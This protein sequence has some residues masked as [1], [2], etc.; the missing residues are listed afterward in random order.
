M[1]SQHMAFV[2]AVPLLCM[3]H[4]SHRELLTPVFCVY[5]HIT[6]LS[7][8]SLYKKGTPPLLPC[9]VFP[10]TLITIYLPPTRM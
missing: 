3:E 9:F 2:T 4:S 5:V 6:P 8:A 1:A 7:D 10:S